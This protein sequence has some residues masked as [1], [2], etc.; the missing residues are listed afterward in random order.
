MPSKVVPMRQKKAP[1]REKSL[2][3]IVEKVYTA[4]LEHRLA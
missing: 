1:A 3:E 4:I 2:E